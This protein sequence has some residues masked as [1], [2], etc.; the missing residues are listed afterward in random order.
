MLE[1]W[2]FIAATDP[3]HPKKLVSQ[4]KEFRKIMIQ[5]YTSVFV[6]NLLLSG[7][8][9]KKQVTD[10]KNRVLYYTILASEVCTSVSEQYDATLGQV[11]HVDEDRFL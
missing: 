9:S 5:L 6:Y 10:M 3:K 8:C 7:E 4:Q 11:Q 1:Q 2:P